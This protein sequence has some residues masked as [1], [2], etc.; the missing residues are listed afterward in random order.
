MKE[1]SENMD[2]IESIVKKFSAH[3]SIL[4]I[5]EVINKSIFSFRT[6]DICEVENSKSEHK[7]GQSL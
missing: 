6:T 2:P 3:P 7:Q 1:V 5:K 4:K